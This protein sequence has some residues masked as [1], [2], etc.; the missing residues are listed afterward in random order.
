[1]EKKA[2]I[3]IWKFYPSDRFFV[4][5]DG[6]ALIVIDDVYSRLQFAFGPGAWLTVEYWDG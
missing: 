6:G 2:A 3:D 5:V 4:K 1:M